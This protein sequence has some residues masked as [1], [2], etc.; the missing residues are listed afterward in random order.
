MNKERPGKPSLEHSYERRRGIFIPGID[1]DASFGPCFVLGVFHIV[2]ALSFK[3]LLFMMKLL[4]E[5]GRHMEDFT[6][7]PLLL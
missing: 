7:P 1:S 2:L 3:Q 5:N 4:S 6:L